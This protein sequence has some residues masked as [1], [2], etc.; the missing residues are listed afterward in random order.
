MSNQGEPVVFEDA[1]WAKEM[2]PQ[3]LLAPRPVRVLHPC[4][5]LNAP[6]RA[7]R[8]MCMPWVSTGDFE[9]NPPCEDHLQGLLPI[10]LCC[11]S[12]QSLEMCLG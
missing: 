1:E 12:G 3:M 10:L 4:A 7:A 11:T 5:G 9:Q 2:K 8:E 6:E